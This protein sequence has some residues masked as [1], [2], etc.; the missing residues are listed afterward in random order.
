MKKYLQ[1]ENNIISWDVE[2]PQR[3]INGRKKDCQVPINNTICSLF[4]S[5]LSVLGLAL[6]DSTLVLEFS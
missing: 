4:I 5:I 3:H 6:E 2:R 1:G